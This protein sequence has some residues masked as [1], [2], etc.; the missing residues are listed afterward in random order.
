VS[1]KKITQEQ[2]T[3]K[4]LSP[5][6]VH[7]TYYDEFEHRKTRYLSPIDID[8][9]EYV[10]INLIHKLES[11]Y[12]INA[13]I[14]VELIPI[15]LKEKDKFITTFKQTTIVAWKGTYCLSGEIPIL[16]F[17]YD[18]GIGSKNSQGFGMFELI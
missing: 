8:F 12:Q 16:Q 14:G 7:S 15:S 1:N 17:L 11:I 2:L 18:A 13:P 4:M 10:N 9:Q 3:I 6:C 5:L